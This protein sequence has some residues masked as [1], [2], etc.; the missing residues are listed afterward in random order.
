MIA[1]TKNSGVTMKIEIHDSPNK[2]LLSTGDGWYFVLSHHDDI[3]A[4]VVGDAP[5][6]F[7]GLFAK[8]I[9]VTDL[10]LDQR[11]PGEKELRVR[12]VTTN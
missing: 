11:V 5:V 6:C 12:Y 7:T 9:R 3:V 4:A 8:T 2:V 10:H 1:A